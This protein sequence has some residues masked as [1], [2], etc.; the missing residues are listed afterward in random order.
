MSQLEV[1]HAWAGMFARLLER[2]ESRSYDHFEV[3]IRSDALA[4]VLVALIALTANQTSA[5]HLNSVISFSGLQK[6]DQLLN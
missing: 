3:I 4:S 2:F 6:L 1:L 5:R